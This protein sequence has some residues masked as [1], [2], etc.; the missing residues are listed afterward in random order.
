[1]IE[2]V[3]GDI[4]NIEGKVVVYSKFEGNIMDFLPASL[5][6]KL[7]DDE[8]EQFAVCANERNVFAFYGA[9]DPLAF[10]EKLG[11]PYSDAERVSREISKHIQP[12]ETG[13]IS[14]QFY[15]TAIFESETDILCSP[16]DII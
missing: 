13:V 4:N 11:I 6:K 5:K 1:M 2:L 8:L 7:S 14:M 9:T 16:T 3:K 12:K 10:V 15:A